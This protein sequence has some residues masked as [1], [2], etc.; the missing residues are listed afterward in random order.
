MVLQLAHILFNDS[1]TKYNQDLTNFLSRNIE[2]LIM[3]GQIKFKFEIVKPKQ[4][5][6]LRKKGMTR[7][8]AMVYMKKSFI[9]VPDII[10]EL[11][12][13]VKN[14]KATALQK[15]AE[16]MIDDFQK[17][18]MFVTKNSDGKFVVP[19]DDDDNDAPDL[20]GDLS[21]EVARRDK[22]S[23][24]KA[25]REP[26]QKTNRSAYQSDDNYEQERPKK[27][28]ADN[29]DVDDDPI[30]SLNKI[31]SKNRGGE[32][33]GNDDDMMATLLAKMGSD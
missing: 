28:R 1:P 24:K 13:T 5:A 29:I 30:K 18:S 26:P 22:G 12:V 6:E 8:P 4:I 14:S 16:E 20:E 3:K 2:T 19:P 9:G 15:T 23:K 32:D 21:R 17:Q 31:K 33:G 25:D 10:A 27:Q 7:L 11:S